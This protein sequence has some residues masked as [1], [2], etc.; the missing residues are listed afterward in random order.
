M[1]SLSQAVAEAVARIV[2]CVCEKAA[3]VG[4]GPMC[5]CGQVASPVPSWDYCGQCDGDHCGM[6]YVVV[7]EAFP[8]E[9]FPEPLE[10]ALC[11]RPL[12]INIHV[13][14]L[15]CAPMPSDN[16]TLPNEA[17]HMDSHL[18]VIADMG[19][20]Y[21]AVTCCGFRD[22]ATSGWTALPE[23]GG[24]VGGRWEFTVSLDG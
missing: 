2:D 9:G 17:D 4:A 13:G 16:G 10:Y 12:A 7:T 20:I 3:T 21:E 6:A 23:T 24:C 8:Y 11:D 1:N 14:A 18:A 5:F 19:A 22:V 15:R